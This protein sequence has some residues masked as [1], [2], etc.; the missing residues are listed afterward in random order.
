[1][2]FLANENFNNDI[3][4]ALKSEHP[5]LDIVRVQDT[6]V[7]QAEDPLVLEFAAIR[8]DMC[9]CASLRHQF[10]YDYISPSLST[11]FALSIKIFWRTSS[12]SS[13]FSKSR[14]QR[15]GLMTG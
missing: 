6:E 8:L 11:F 15:S 10:L 13:R 4:R 14:S 12:L 7:Y 9:P 1:M 3:L 2:R 5:E